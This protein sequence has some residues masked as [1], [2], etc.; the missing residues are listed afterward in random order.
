MNVLLAQAGRGGGG[1]GPDAAIGG[2][3]VCLYFGLILVGL[4]IYIL[5][6]V[7][8]SKCLGA[9]SPRNRRMEPGQAWLNLIPFFNLVW[10]ILSVLRIAESLED[11]FEDRRLRGDGDYGKTIGIVFY[12]GQLVCFPVGLVCGIMY[13]MKLNG[14]SRELLEGGYDDEDD[15]RPRRKSRRDDD[16]DDDD[17]DRPRRRRRD[18]DYDD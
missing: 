8:M 17:D 11:E 2:V 6:L 1:G 9:V 7:A 5:V 12:V 15:D 16:D 4:V 3:F 10:L 13:M 18:D 14:Y